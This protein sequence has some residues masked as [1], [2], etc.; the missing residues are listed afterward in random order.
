[1]HAHLRERFYQRYGRELTGDI[2]R[3]LLAQ[4]I[5]AHLAGYGRT[6]PKLP[7]RE[8]VRVAFRGEEIRVVWHPGRRHIITFLAPWHRDYTF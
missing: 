7:D 2:L 3:Q 6:E 4:V 5:T 8:H 1:M